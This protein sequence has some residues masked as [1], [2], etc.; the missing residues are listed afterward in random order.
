MRKRIYELTI[1]GL[2]FFLNPAIILGIWAL[3][4]LFWFFTTELSLKSKIKE[5]VII[6]AL[7]YIDPM[8]IMALWAIEVLIW[9]ASIQTKPIKRIC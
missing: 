1:I 6:G 7:F 3:E 4:L 9:Y 2:C 5:L 8:V